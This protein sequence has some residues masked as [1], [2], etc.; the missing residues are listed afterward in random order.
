VGAST[1]AAMGD[2]RA[3]GGFATP[4]GGAGGNGAGWICVWNVHR[5]NEVWK[6]EE[7]LWLDD[8][9]KSPHNGRGLMN[10]ALTQ[11]S[12]GNYPV[13]LAY[14]ENALNYTPN[15]P[16]LEINLGVVNAAMADQGDAVRSV[17]AERHFVR[18][19]ELAP[20][21]DTT[22]A[23]YGRWLAISEGREQ[24]GDRDNCK[25]RSR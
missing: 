14:F 20:E 1:G 23:F 4:G 7:S 19:T 2:S 22:H 10:Y 18:A 16:T 12:K 5:R 11:L 25:R 21:E 24:E 17:E 9:Q 15:Y 3:A 8:V 13:A 6:D